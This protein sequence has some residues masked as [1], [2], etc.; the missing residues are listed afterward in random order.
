MG[1]RISQFRSRESAGVSRGLVAHV[2]VSVNAVNPVRV[3]A[4]RITNKNALPFLEHVM[5]IREAIIKF[6]A[7]AGLHPNGALCVS[8]YC[9]C[10]LATGAAG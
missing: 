6:V 3:S 8:R 10:N 2:S 1:L 9:T 7:L 4:N 5:S